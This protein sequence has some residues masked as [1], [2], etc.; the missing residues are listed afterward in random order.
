MLGAARSFGLVETQHGGFV[1]M[2]RLGRNVLDDAERSNAL[3]EAFLN[4]PLHAKMYEQYQGNA[5]PPPAAVERHMEGLGVP[6]KQKE[7]ARQTFTKSARFAGFIDSSTERFIRPATAPDLPA[8]SA[9]RWRNCQRAADL[10]WLV[11]EVV[12]GLA[13]QRDDV[14]VGF[15]DPVR[16][17][18]VAHELPDILHRVQLSA[19][20]VMLSGIA[21]LGVKCQPA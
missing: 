4:V 3:A 15:E 19:R 21:S 20:T 10:P 7:R 6:P 18:V 11:D 17:P 5:L 9:S 12:P 16:Q 8:A 1:S 2:T 14:F 13:A